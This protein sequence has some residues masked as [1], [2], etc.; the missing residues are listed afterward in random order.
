MHGES[1]V[2]RLL[3]RESVI[4]DLDALGFTGETR[5]RLQQ[6]LA[7]ASGMLMVPGPTGSGKTHHSLYRAESAYY[8]QPQTDYRG[9]PC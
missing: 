1:V 8:R 7:A 5:S 2:M 3:N 4:L 6:V 9:R